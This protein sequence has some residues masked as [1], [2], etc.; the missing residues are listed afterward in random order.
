MRA[1]LVSHGAAGKRRHT[2]G[3]TATCHATMC[4]KQR[5]PWQHGRTGRRTHNNIHSRRDP[6]R[7][8]AVDWFATACRVY[9][10]HTRAYSVVPRDHVQHAASAV[11]ARPSRGT[12]H[13]RLTRLDPPRTAA[14]DC[15]A[16]ALR[17]Y[18]RHTWAYSDMPGN[19][20]QRAAFGVATRPNTSWHTSQHTLSSRPHRAHLRS[21]GSQRL[22]VCAR[23][24]YPS[25]RHHHTRV[26]R[27]H[28]A[29]RP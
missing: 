21:I 8:A 19:H 14:V 12:R 1:A 26:H 13:N 2:H 10:R 22:F 29:F 7:T 18:A 20:V 27:A 5:L 15:F 17:V 6:P 9:A 16:T 23:G 24:T 28:A 4:S 11:A 25:V 3:R